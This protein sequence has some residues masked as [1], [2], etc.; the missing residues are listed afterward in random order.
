MSSLTDMDDDP[1][2]IQPE[3]T[4]RYI[5]LGSAGAVFQDSS[6]RVIKTP[7]KHDVTGCSQQVI[8]TVQHIES[9]SELC[10]SREKL[11][12][13]TLPKNPNVL[14]CLAITDRG[15][16][17]PYHR[18]GNLREY[19]QH[20][21][22]RSHTRDQWIQ[23]AIDAVALIHSYGVIHA[24][25]SPRNFL[26]AEDLSIK[27]CDFAGS[28]IGDLKPLVEEEDRYRISPW[29]PRT[30]KTDLFALGCLIYEIST[31][32]RPYNEIDDLEE[33][34]RLY[35]ANV[36]PN[37][38]GLRY[39]DVINKCWT[40]QYA[41]AGMLQ[42]D[43]SLCFIRDKGLDDP[44]SRRHLCSNLFQSPSIR[45][46]LG[47]ASAVSAFFWIYRKRNWR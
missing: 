44:S 34:E 15:L 23:N 5:A 26:V 43:F 29:S 20:N 13:Q 33:I 37:L 46:A 17:F 35:S 25:I 18:L 2:L 4:I 27:L 41:S 36:F 47:F 11:I 1:S 42:D 38:E 12:Y 30:F 16:H 28:V 24:D 21:E 9:I 8:E 3:G 7:L 40:S 31:G 19:M 32:V 45:M 10:I 14:D 39:R 22:I 6:D